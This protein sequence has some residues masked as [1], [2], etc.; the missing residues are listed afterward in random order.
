MGLRL[1][2]GGAAAALFLGAAGCGVGPIND[3]LYVSEWK[4]KRD[5]PVQIERGWQYEGEQWERA[6]YV[7]QKKRPTD[8]TGNGV[9]WHPERNEEW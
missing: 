8:W 5:R 9:G 4:S 7:D 6:V 3:R 1:V 2:L